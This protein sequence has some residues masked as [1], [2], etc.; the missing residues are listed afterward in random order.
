MKFYNSQWFRDGVF[1]LAMAMTLIVVAILLAGCSTQR[2]VKVT[3]LP[4][5]E[6]PNAIYAGPTNSWRFTDEIPVWRGD[7]G[8]YNNSP[9]PRYQIVTNL[10][11]IRVRIIQ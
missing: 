8:F 7:P 4:E 10:D 2:V 3:P 1:W 5:K 6:Q 9:T 11:T